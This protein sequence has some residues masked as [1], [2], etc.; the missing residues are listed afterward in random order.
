MKLESM[1][2]HALDI[3]QDTL[4]GLQSAACGDHACEGVG[5]VRARDGEV[6]ESPGETPVLSRVSHMRASRGY[7]LR[8]RVNRCRGL[9]AGRH[10]GFVQNLH[11][12]LGL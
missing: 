12:V 9:L 3:A 6:L 10:A 8:R 7:K 1:R 4:N 2:H 5:D 11:I